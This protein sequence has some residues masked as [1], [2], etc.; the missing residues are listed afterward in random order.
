MKKMILIYGL[1][2]GAFLAGLTTGMV[3]LCLNGKATFDN[4]EVIGYASMVLAFTLVF[5]GIRSYRE[6]VGGGSITF[7]RAFLVGI[8]IVLIA[9]A[10]YVTT[11]EI[12]YF[13]FLPNFAEQYTAFLLNKMK[14]EGASAATIAAKQAEMARFS[15]LY[16]NPLFNIGMTFLE[17]FPVG[18]IVTLMSAG[19]LRKVRTPV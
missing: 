12:A 1:I 10:V 4:S 8:A 11:W 13:N 7:G 5:V 9:S 3:I 16:K 18:L 15:A 14:A 19:I 2:S 6:N 17:I